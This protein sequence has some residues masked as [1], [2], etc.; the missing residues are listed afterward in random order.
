MGSRIV[1]LAC[2]DCGHT[3]P[4]EDGV[5]ETGSLRRIW[6]CPSAACAYAGYLQLDGYA[7]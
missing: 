1:S 5:S 7:C 2:P 6:C 4:L 3:A